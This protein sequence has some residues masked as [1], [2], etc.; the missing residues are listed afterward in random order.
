MK[1]GGVATDM[2]ENDDRFKQLLES[3]A[4]I[5]LATCKMIVELGC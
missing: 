2:G 3:W 5:S 1:G 4:G